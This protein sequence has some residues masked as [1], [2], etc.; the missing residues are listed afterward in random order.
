MSDAFGSTIVVADDCESE[1]TPMELCLPLS[2]VKV[3]C[4]VRRMVRMSVFPESD[5]T[6]VVTEGSLPI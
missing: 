5:G 2:A 3:M 4:T 6:V 1:R